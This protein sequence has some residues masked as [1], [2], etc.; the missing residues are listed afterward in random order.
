[1][2]ATTR[3]RY[4]RFSSAKN[5]STETGEERKPGKEAEMKPVLAISATDPKSDRQCFG[6]SLKERNN[7]GL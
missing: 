4:K 1:M 3:R 7:A 6:V 2:S 5:Y